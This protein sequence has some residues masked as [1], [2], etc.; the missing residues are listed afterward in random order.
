[1]MIRRIPSTIRRQESVSVKTPPPPPP[2]KSS[3]KKAILSVPKPQL[4]VEEGN[5]V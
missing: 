2:P 3:I 1:M 5:R 4:E